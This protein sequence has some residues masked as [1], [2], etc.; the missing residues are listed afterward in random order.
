MDNPETCAHHNY[1]SRT[2]VH[3][4]L[5]WTYKLYRGFYSRLLGSA[6]DSQLSSTYFGSRTRTWSFFFIILVPLGSLAILPLILFQSRSLLRAA[7]MAYARVIGPSLSTSLCCSLLLNSPIYVSAS[8]VCIGPLFRIS[9]SGNASAA[10]PAILSPRSPMSTL[11][12]CR[13]LNNFLTASRAVRSLAYCRI[14]ADFS[15]VQV[16]AGSSLYRPPTFL[17]LTWS[18]SL[19]G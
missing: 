7:S 15:S 2:P 10:R 8:N 5:A 6:S 4:G 19:T 16:R 9:S 12:P 11:S 14:R 13:G 18:T 3:T 1:I 17:I